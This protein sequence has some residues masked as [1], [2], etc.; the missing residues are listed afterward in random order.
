MSHDENQVSKTSGS[1]RNARTP[2]VPHTDGSGSPDLGTVTWPSGQYQA[3]IS[4][5]HQSCRETHQSRMFR[6]HSSYVFFQSSGTKRVSPASVAAMAFS[7]RGATFTNH[8]R[9][10]SGSTIV[11]H[12]WQRARGMTWLFSPRRRPAASR[13]LRTFFLAWRRWRAAEAAPAADVIFPSN[14]I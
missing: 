12:R 2:H 14:P 3:G 4:W 5:P 8:C 13:S 6:I 9:E 1:R 7:A 11:L 10:T